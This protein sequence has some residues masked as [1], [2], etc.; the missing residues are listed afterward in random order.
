[1]AAGDRFGGAD[2]GEGVDGV[3]GSEGFGGFEA[4]EDLARKRRYARDGIDLD[5]RLALLHTHEAGE[6]GATPEPADA[7]AETLERAGVP[8]RPDEG[9]LAARGAVTTAERDEAEAHLAAIEGIGAGRA[10]A[11]LEHFGS[12]EAV[13]AAPL[14]ELAAVAGMDDERA[15]TLQRRLG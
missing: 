15:R 10:R 12:F 3:G 8:P 4:G 2:G 14:D 7:D 1:M 9:D 6:V 11:L 13:R 5:A